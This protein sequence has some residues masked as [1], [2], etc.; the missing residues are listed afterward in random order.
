MRR[1]VF[2]IVLLASFGG[3]VSAQ[4]TRTDAPV[5]PT[6]PPGAQTPESTP[7]FRAETRLRV[8]NISV[9]DKDGNPVEGLTK[10]DFVVTENGVKQEIAF[11]EFQRIAD[12]P[13]AAAPAVPIQAAAPLSAAERSEASRITV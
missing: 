6:T 12:E 13:A 7:T 9:K 10:D 11:V 5:R 2:A 3:L 4:Q 1:A 8:H